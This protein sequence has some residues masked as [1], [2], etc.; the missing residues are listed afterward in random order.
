ME[1]AL[2]PRIRQNIRNMSGASRQQ[3]FWCLRYLSILP[4]KGSHSLAS[5]TIPLTD[6]QT[7]THISECRYDELIALHAKSTE[8]RS[9]F[10]PFHLR[11]LGV[12][13]EI[14]LNEADA[15]LKSEEIPEKYLSKAGLFASVFSRYQ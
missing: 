15:A 11:D 12:E 10:F 4:P 13:I 8:R 2:S 14:A 1:P 9:V 7:A 3:F 6:S 5:C